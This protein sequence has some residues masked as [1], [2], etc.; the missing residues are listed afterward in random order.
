[1]KSYPVKTPQQLGAVL[2]GCRKARKLT[3]AQV[4]ARVGLPQKEISKLEMSPAN[5]SL[6]RVFKL[7][8]ALELEIVVRERGTADTSSEW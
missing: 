2:Q 3:Q 5:T 6:A 7:L 4:G 1:M 8:A